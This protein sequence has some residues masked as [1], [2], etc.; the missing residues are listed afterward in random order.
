MIIIPVSTAMYRVLGKDYV[1]G[2]DVEVRGPEL[3]EQAQEE[4]EG[5]IVRRHRLT[6]DIK[7]SVD[8]RNLTEIQEALSSTTET[9]SWL[10]GSIAVIS[11]LVGGIGI[12]NIMLV[13][14]TERTREIGLR[15]A[16]GARAKDIMT[17]FIIEAVVMSVSGGL[18]GIA[19]GIGIAAALSFA[20]GWTTKVSL[21]AIALA[22][23]FSIGVGMVFGIWPARKASQLNPI[24]ALRYE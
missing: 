2:I 6:G 21:S 5:L 10:L 8:I 16:I 1:D 9:M 22:T 13:S 18:I 7:E 23:L 20:A 4:I 11:L 14:V 19:I 3:I 12:M 24:E 15:K 17:Q